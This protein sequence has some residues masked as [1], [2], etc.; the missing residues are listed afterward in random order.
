MHSWP[1]FDLRIRTPR[2]ELRLPDLELLNELA[3]LAGRGIHDPDRMPFGNSW[4]DKPSPELERSVVQFGLLQVATWA[5]D[6]WIYN[7]VAIHDGR[8][9]GT[10][11]IKGTEFSAARSFSTG[12]WL[13]REYQGRGFGREMRAAILHLGFAGLGAEEAQT[14]AFSDNPA[15][16]AVSRGLG[17]EPNGS[18]LVSRRGSRVQ[19]LAYRLTR[20]RWLATHTLEVRLQGVEHCLDL[21]GLATG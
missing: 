4:T 7:P 9:I 20:E 18:C 5:R 15:S 19:H 8:V 12:S 21:F 1:L 2:L 16:L 10:Q 17:Y 3:I 14:S 11:S 6:R 13:G